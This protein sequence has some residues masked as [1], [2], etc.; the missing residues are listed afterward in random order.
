ML[1]CKRFNGTG[2]RAEIL[3][4]LYFFLKTIDKFVRWD[5]IVKESQIDFV[6]I[7]DPEGG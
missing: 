6:N 7:N 5:I 1:K 4:I 3:L 2:W